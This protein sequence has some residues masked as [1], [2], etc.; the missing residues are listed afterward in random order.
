MNIANR[1]HLRAFL[2]VLCWLHLSG[3]E[4]APPQAKLLPLPE[5]PRTIELSVAIVVNPDLPAIDD[6]R[7]AGILSAAAREFEASFGKK[8]VFGTPHRLSVRALFDRFPARFKQFAAPQIFDFKRGTGDLD[9]LAANLEKELRRSGSS[10]EHLFAYAS[11]H[12]IV[13]PSTSDFQG[14]AR[15][16][17]E[18]HIARLG[19]LAREPAAEGKLLITEEPYN[20]YVYWA[21]LREADFPYDVVITNQ[22]LASAEYLE[23]QLHT[24]LRGGIS[25]GITSE[26]RTCAYGTYSLLSAYPFWGA[27]ATTVEL[28]GGHMLSEDEAT[29]AAALMLVHELGDQLLHLGHPYGLKAC[30][31]N[32]PELLRFLDWIRAVEPGGCSREAHPT[33]VPGFQK[34]RDHRTG[35]RRR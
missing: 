28:R 29:R 2:A 25:N 24:S 4:Q 12:L 27:D 14:L 5:L 30:A 34:F 35:D 15:A 3:C 10:Y 32:P 16:L 9:R 20:E 8:I 26:C 11:P 13:R 31:M 17:A 1:R 21:S 19:R 6:A 7:V 23:S 18:T 22:L 33:L